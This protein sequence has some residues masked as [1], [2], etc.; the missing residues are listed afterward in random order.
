[1]TITTAP[2]VPA[3]L[4]E[5]ARAVCERFDL[6]DQKAFGHIAETVAA[7]LGCG[8]D[9]GHFAPL[10]RSWRDHF[11]RKL[12]AIAR[13]LRESYGTNI[14]AGESQALKT[15]IAQTLCRTSI[16]KA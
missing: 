12:D 6:Q 11:E 14:L 3:P 5:V 15:L 10:P 2:D 4:G 1:M 13:T 7:G 8:G 9:Q 16:A